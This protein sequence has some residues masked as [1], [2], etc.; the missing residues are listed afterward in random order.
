M[1]RS[2]RVRH[3]RWNEHSVFI[4]STRVLAFCATIRPGKSAFW[5]CRTVANPWRSNHGHAGQARRRP[6]FDEGGEPR[7]GGMASHPG[8]APAPSAALSGTGVEQ[9]ELPAPAGTAR[10][11]PQLEDWLR[12][13]KPRVRPVRVLQILADAW[14]LRCLPQFIG[15]NT[16]PQTGPTKGYS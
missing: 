3:L 9:T 13:C 16:G 10:H 5:S 1:T 2:V 12:R 7:S 6:W 8:E 4:D 15:C 11:R 14:L